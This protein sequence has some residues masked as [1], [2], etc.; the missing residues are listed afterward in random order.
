[1]EPNECPLAAA[2]RELLEETG[3]RG[4]IHKWHKKNSIP[5]DINIHA[6]PASPSKQEPEHFHYDFRYVFVSNGILK[7]PRAS[8]DIVAWKNIREIEEKNLKE[9]ISKLKFENILAE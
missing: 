3:L 5:I 1:M 8:D 2:Q 4:E 9:L 7:A 6:I